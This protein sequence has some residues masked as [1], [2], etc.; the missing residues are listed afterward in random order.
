MSAELISLGAQRFAPVPWAPHTAAVVIGKDILELLS[1]SMYIDPMSIFREYVQNAVDAIDDARRAGVLAQEGIGSVSVDV[2]AGARSIKIRDNGIG[3]DH[4]EFVPRLTAFGASRKRG[5][6]ARGF[7]GVGRLAGLGYCQELIFRSRAYGNECVSELKWDC[8]KLRLLLRGTDF[9][10][11]LSELVSQTVV[12]RSIDGRGLP[13]HFFEVELVGVVRHRN[14]QLLNAAAVQDYLSE[15][16]PIPFASG[17]RYGPQIVAALRAHLDL[18]GIEIH[19]NGAAEPLCRPHRDMIEFGTGAVDNFNDLEVFEI[20]G[21]NGGLAAIGWVLHHD[22]MGALPARSRVKGLRLRS[23]NIQVGGD[24][25]LQELFPEPRFNSWT[26]GEV[27]V[28][29][30]RLVPNGRRDHFEQNIHLFNLFNQ[31]GPIAR[32]IS[33]RC[34]TSSLR[35]KWTRDFE[36]HYEQV[37][38]KAAILRQRTLAKQDNTRVAGQVE[39]LFVLMGKITMIELLDAVTRESMGARLRNQRRSITRLLQSEGAA[40]PLAH[41]SPQK[42]RA[43][44]RVFGLI[45]ECSP[46]QGGA[47]ALVDRIIARLKPEK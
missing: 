42:R 37:A 30:R 2:N 44:E 29:D 8:R 41:L 36:R 43:Y 9:R 23:G 12:T 14:D 1:T 39:E 33:R 47:K 25:L 38:T 32:E 5:T 15:I 26:V 28:L 20:P 46:S 31:I 10:G 11:H 21:D 16:A 34:R 13:E 6:S 7:R 35:R 45:Y 18:G 3:L 40:S 27:H 24:D 19:V 22:Y 17:F 4:K